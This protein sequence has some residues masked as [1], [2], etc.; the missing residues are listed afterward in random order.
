M[1]L[2]RKRGVKNIRVPVVLGCEITG[3]LVLQM[4]HRFQ[5][6]QFTNL[7]VQSSLALFYQTYTGTHIE[8][9]YALHY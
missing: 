4:S 9:I 6:Q 7:I 8:P 2:E 3:L 1:Y 5:K